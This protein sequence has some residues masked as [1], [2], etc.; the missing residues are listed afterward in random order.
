VAGPPSNYE[1]PVNLKALNGAGY[2]NNKGKYG[3][4]PA[5]VLFNKSCL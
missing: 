2:E 4:L 3:Q 5:A 1:K